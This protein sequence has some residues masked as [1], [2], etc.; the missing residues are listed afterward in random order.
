MTVTFVEGCLFAI[1]NAV[2]SPNTPAPIMMT[3]AGK[4]FCAETFAT[5]GDSGIMTSIP[6]F[7]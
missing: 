1:A 6:E 7:D 4:D 2:D 5:V 3:V